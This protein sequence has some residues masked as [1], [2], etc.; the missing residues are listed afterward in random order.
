ALLLGPPRV[1]RSVTSYL[2]IFS[3]AANH[4]GAKTNA[5]SRIA[6]DLG[7]MSVPPLA[8]GRNRMPVRRHWPRAMIG[9]SATVK[10]QRGGDKIFLN[11]AK[12]RK[13]APVWDLRR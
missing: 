8:H 9:G 7:F 6:S 2:D 10:A 4:V 5:N 12:W 11:F 1:P 13:I 3:L